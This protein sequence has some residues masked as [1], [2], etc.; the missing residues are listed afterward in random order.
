MKI[1]SLYFILRS[2]SIIRN[3]SYSNTIFFL[4]LANVCTQNSWKRT[5]PGFDL[6]KPIVKEEVIFSRIWILFSLTFTVG[7]IILIIFSWRAVSE[8]QLV[9]KI[10]IDTPVYFDL[11]TVDIW[12]FLLLALV[13]GKL[14]NYNYNWYAKLQLVYMTFSGHKI[15]LPI[16][17]NCHVGKS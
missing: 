15:L 4:I 14:K 13:G 6:V 17:Q 7:L 10:L 11:I 5:F 9:K 2:V 8:Y 12:Y 16:S 3:V 1:V